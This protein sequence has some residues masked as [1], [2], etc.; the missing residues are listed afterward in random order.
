M[1]YIPQPIENAHVTLPAELGELTE[2]LAENAHEIWAAQRMKDGW[3]WGPQRDD[4]A[5][6]H[7]CLVPYDQLPESEKEYDRAAVLCVL[8]AIVALGAKILPPAKPSENTANPGGAN[9]AIG[10]W[11]EHFKRQLSLVERGFT[12]DIEDGP[13]QALLAAA[14]PLNEAIGFLNDELHEPYRAADEAA[15]AHQKTH[16]CLAGLAISAGV[17]AILLVIVQLGLAQTWP[18]W[19]ILAARVELAA[20]A[21]GVVAVGVGLIAR[22][23]SHWLIQRHVAER[24]RMLKF[25]ALGRAELW[26]GEMESW[27]GWVRDQAQSARKITTIQQVK[28]WA[29]GGE[30]EPVEP[31]PP[32]CSASRAALAAFSEYYRWKRVEFQAAYFGKQARK[33]RTQSGPLA[34]SGLPLFL[35]TIVAVVVHAGA[36][37]MAASN[38][39]AGNEPGAHGWHLVAVWSLALAALLPVG[40]LGIRAWLGA[41]EPVRGAN[42]FEA[43]QRALESISEKLAADRGDLPATL[44]H[45]AHVE[46]FL[47]HEHREWLRLMLEAEWFL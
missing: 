47:A 46:H 43:K 40:S 44:H 26:C 6:K 3:Q 45:I 1:K 39:A 29:V 15:K 30:A 14:G 18:A 33:Y 38:Q 25:E 24:L 7:P 27:K 10:L 34:H 42:L 12:L 23:N 5:R 41:F 17:L 21:A 28:A 9:V 4:A 8:R 11:E 22:F 37:T 19:T 36:D 35:L 16:R 31:V 13:E 2:R 32:Q 20:F